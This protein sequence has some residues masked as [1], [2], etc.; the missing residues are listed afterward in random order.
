[1]L[2]TPTNILIASRGFEKLFQDAYDEATPFYPELVSEVPSNSRENLYGWMQKLPRMRE[3]LGDRVYHN[4]AASEYIIRNKKWELSVK[5]GREDFED[6]SYG[7]YNPV[8]QDIGQ[9]ARM[10]P[11]DL[12]AD[13]LLNGEALLGTDGQNHFDT[14]HSV[15]PRRASMG[16]QSNY[17]ASGKALN[18]ANFAIVRASMM[19]LKGEDGKPLKVRPTMLVVP[20]SLEVTA[21]EIVQNTLVT[22][23]GTNVLQGMAKVI[24]IDDLEAEPDA[25]YL[26]D[27]RRPIKPLV[28]QKRRATNFVAL[29]AL[30]DERVVHYDEYVWGADCRDNAGYGPWF[31]SFKARA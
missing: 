12:I 15:N 31:L 26:M 4:L 20:P 30:T 5:V 16:T 1:M 3:W 22:Q 28:Y 24:V 11:D 7:I 18:A 17:F 23:G 27:G 13:L 2:I 25:W 19:G 6:D 10:H 14:D 9:Q 8:V 29:T 21:K